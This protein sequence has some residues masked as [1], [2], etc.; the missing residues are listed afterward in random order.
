MFNYFL[1]H[2]LYSMAI[3]PLIICLRKYKQMDKIFHPFVYYLLALSIDAIASPISNALLGSNIMLGNMYILAEAILLV[4][5]YHKW[6]VIKAKT[7]KYLIFLIVII[8]IIEKSLKPLLYYNS[9]FLIIYSLLLV[10]FSVESINRNHVF[11]NEGIRRNPKFLI[12]ITI[13]FSFSINAA[14]E[15]LLLNPSRFTTMFQI[16]ILDIYKISGWLL[17]LSHTF[18]AIWIPRK[19]KYISTY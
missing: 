12:S 7:F 16:K 3:I 8:W 2:A 1:V 17:I 14:F 5:L 9:I 10:F 13:A 15:I 4:L 11:N 6:G 19:P 18:S